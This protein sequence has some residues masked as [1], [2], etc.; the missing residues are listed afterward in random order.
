MAD[1]FS[2][3]KRSEVMRQVK[4]TGN[5]S[6]E[7]K[8]I[9]FF[10]EKGITGWRRRYN[11]N[12]HPDFLKQKIAIFVDGCFW[13]GH[14]CRNTR[15]VQDSDYWDKKRQKNIEHDDKINH[16]FQSRGWK[17]I[18]IWECELLKKN[19]SILEGKLQ[20]ILKKL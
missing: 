10:H 6:T 13:H 20:L 19:R 4:S 15:P 2:K 17:V 16:L 3:E 1:I 5:K 8:L 18:R 14:D 11:V 7:E 12:G 9:A